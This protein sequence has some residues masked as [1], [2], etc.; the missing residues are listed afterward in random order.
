[1][2]KP[3]VSNHGT[4]G[5]QHTPWM[6]GWLASE[7]TARDIIAVK[8]I[9]IDLCDGNLHDGLVLSQIIFW[10]GKNKET[11]EDRL[12]VFK[13]GHYWLAKTYQDWWEECRVK[14]RTARECIVRLERRGLIVTDLFKFNGAPT[15]HIRMN[16]EAFENAIRHLMSNGNDTTCQMDLPSD[17]SSLTETTGKDDLSKTTAKLTTSTDQGTVSPRPPFL[18]KSGGANQG[19]EAGQHSSPVQQKDQKPHTPGSGS[20]KQ[21]SAAPPA[22][23]VFWKPEDELALDD[24]GWIKLPTKAEIWPNDRKRVGLAKLTAMRKAQEWLVNQGIKD[25]EWVEMDNGEFWIEHKDGYDGPEHPDQAFGKGGALPL[26]KLRD[27]A[28]DQDSVSQ[29][30]FND[31]LAYFFWQ[32]WDEVALAA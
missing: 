23:K 14:D 21:R 19:G 5:Y 3:S 25:I 9:Y 4:V 27:L 32:A 15:K 26:G 29:G 1:M 17:G 28:Y 24:K 30:E 22:Q 10:H 6:Q 7:D 18:E 2:P 20:K 11:G 16:R 31:A 12:R 8:R 13:D